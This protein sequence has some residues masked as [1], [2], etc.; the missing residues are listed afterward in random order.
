METK[1]QL[2]MFVLTTFAGNKDT[3]VKLKENLIPQLSPNDKWIIAYDKL[4]LLSAVRKFKYLRC[5]KDPILL[6]KITNNDSVSNKKY[7]MIIYRYLA[8]IYFGVRMPMAIYYMFYYA[9]FGVMRQIKI[10]V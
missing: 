7:K 5:I 4:F 8:L 10:G 3:L 2:P 9:F 6:Y 1:N